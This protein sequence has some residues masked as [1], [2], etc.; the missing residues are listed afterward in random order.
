MNNIKNMDLSIIMPYHNEGP[1]FINE[2]LQSI[3]STIDVDYEIIIV[4]DFSDVPLAID[5]PDVKV[6]RQRSNEGV[7]RAFDRGVALATSE[8]LFLMGCD[9]RFIANNWA[10]L[11]CREILDHPSSLIC[12]SVVHLSEGMPELTFELSRQNFVYNGATI[13]MAWG[14]EEWNILKAE[15]YPRESR[16]MKKDNELATRMLAP[17][18]VVPS[19]TESYEVACILG[20]A[21]G[22]TKSW[23]NHIDGWWGHRKWGT[24]EP[25]ISLKCW[26]FGG[27]CLTAPHIETGHIFKSQGAHGTGYKYIAYNSMLTAWLL[28]DRDDREWLIRHLRN[29][30]WVLEAKA[31]IGDELEYV[32]HRRSLYKAKTVTSI[33]EIVRKFKLNF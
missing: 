9:V 7:G 15:W 18:G 10:S 21:Y 33:N 32:L 23:Y 19:M 1:D 20:A 27:S 17:Y 6:V 28:F 12:T 3:R 22:V 13:L 14:K 2:T 24:L 25:Y 30:D 31:M 8:Q 29:H 26:L 4:D 5:A 11:M 16:M